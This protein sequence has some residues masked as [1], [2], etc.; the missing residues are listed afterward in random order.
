MPDVDE[1]R[2]VLEARKGSQEAFRCLVERHMRRAYALAFRFVNDHHD[3]EEIAQ[4][5]FVRAFESLDGFRAEAEFGTWLY[6][7]IT[8]L[9]LNRLK[10]GKRRRERSV[11]MN[12]AATV[13]DETVFQASHND[14]VRMHIER[15][16]H[17]LPTLQRAVVILRHLH[18]LSTREVSVILHCTE[19]TVKT[20]LFRGMEKMRLKL[21]FLREEV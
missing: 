8:N 16:L 17:E 14:D 18:G 19:G 7:I 13:P 5:A 2:L 6:R 4:E 15:A 21:N 20:H 9:S 1:H 10:D 11:D 3:A 12:F